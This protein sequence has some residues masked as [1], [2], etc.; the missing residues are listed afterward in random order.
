MPQGKRPPSLD[1]ALI[2]WRQ[3]YPDV[4]V[5]P[6]LVHSRHPD[7][8]LLATTVHADLVVVGSK[9]EDE[10]RGLPGGS[11]RHALVHHAQCP[12]VIVH[13]E[14]RPGR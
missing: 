12:V 14:R 4:A 10:I 2:G 5:R 6:V 8:K 9:G 11:V 3:K 1:A 7:R 13:D